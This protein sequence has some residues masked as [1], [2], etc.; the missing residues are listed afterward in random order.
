MTATATPTR[1]DYLEGRCTHAEYYRAVNKTAGIRYSP[2]SPLVV[3]ARAALK[4]GDQHLNSIPLQ[5][6]DSRAASAQTSIAT[7]LHKHGD[8][9][10]L[11][12]GVCAMKQAVIDA[13]NSITEPA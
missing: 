8:F 11:A 2:D 12:G 3:Q 6:W 10:S 5:Q 7:A 4:T 1:A 9:Y 13:A